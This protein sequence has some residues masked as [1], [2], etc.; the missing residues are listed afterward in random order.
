M[1]IRITATNVLLKSLTKERINKKFTNLGGKITDALTAIIDVREE[2]TKSIDDRFLIKCELDLGTK[3]VRAEERGRTVLAAVDKSIDVLAAQAKKVTAKKI[4]RRHASQAV[5]NI[6]P[7]TEMPLT[8]AQLKAKN[9]TLMPIE[10]TDDE[11]LQ[12]SYKNP[13]PFFVFVDKNTKLL[14]IVDEVKKEIYIIKVP[15]IKY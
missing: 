1:D 3:K 13:L 7:P 5:R 15:K 14:K 8:K 10:L 6:M 11:A 12:E 9:K 2:G 4:N